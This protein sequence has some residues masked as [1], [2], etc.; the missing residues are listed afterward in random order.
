MLDVD[1][2]RR[3]REKIDKRG[4]GFPAATS[5]VELEIL[6]MLF[7]EEEAR[8][9][10]HM[11][12]DLET[13]RQI[14][15]R[16]KQAPEKLAAVLERM[17]EKGL[18]FPKRTGEVSYYAAAPYA[19]GIFEHQVGRMD[20]DLARLFEDYL[21]A[22]KVAEEPPPDRE[23]EPGIPL[24]TVPV[25]APVDISHPVAPYDD[26]K[27]IIERN[28][29]IAVANCVCSVQQAELGGSCDR[30]REVC[31]LLGFYAEYYVDQG[32]ARWVSREEALS[33]LDIAEAAGLVHQPSNGAE[34]GA[35]CNCCPDCCLSL[36]V[37]NTFSN[38][39]QLAKSNHFARVAADS[40]S[41]CGICLDPCPMDALSLGEDQVVAID[42]GRCIGCGLCV[43]SCPTEALMLVSKPKEA[44]DVP[45]GSG[46]F[47][48][49]S[50]DIEGTI[51]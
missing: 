34:P 10:L 8:V 18:V 40:C 45:T 20:E 12:W 21:W 38:A 32:N 22:E 19:H 6:E 29:R 2:Y 47:M 4:V 25:R 46:R 43:N 26:V 14:A 35:I 15:E 28:D 51:A 23:I 7:S 17:A 50:T 49:S 9:Y 1:V 36:R 41:G 33:I 24:R 3:L 5:G 42:L 11:S 13:P 44:R 31:L 39:A 16:M 30:P 27:D 37:M 48:R